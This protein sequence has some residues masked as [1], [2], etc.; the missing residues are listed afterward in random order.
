VN[1]LIFYFGAI[2]IIVFFVSVIITRFKDNEIDL[3][4]HLWIIL[5][6]ILIM[7][8][9][10]IAW[11]VIELLLISNISQIHNYNTIIEKYSNG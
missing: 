7:V 10:I 2:L 8:L 11:R 3:K 6:Y 1:N 9:A 4:E 5:I